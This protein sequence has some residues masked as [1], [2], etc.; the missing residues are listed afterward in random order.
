MSKESKEKKRPIRF[1][2]S[3]K[4]YKQLKEEAI[5]MDVPLS[6]YIKMK[7]VEEKNGN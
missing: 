4:R 6:N 3:L 2:V 1:L 7:L 5:K